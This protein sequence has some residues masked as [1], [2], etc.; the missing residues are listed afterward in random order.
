MSSIAARSA[1]LVDITG[2]NRRLAAALVIAA[3]LLAARRLSV[4]PKTVKT[5]EEYDIIIVGGGQYLV[6]NN[7]ISI[8]TSFS[9]NFWVC[10]GFQIVRELEHTRFIT[11]NWGKVWAKHYAYQV[12]L[13]I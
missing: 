9:R 3:M 12:V 4:A 7:G 8:L 2:R 11:R 1:F 5:A 10:F 13:L 6:A